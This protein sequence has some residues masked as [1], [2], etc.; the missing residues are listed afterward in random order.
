MDLNLLFEMN[1]EDYPEVGELLTEI[2]KWDR[3]ASASSYGAGAYAVFYYQLRPYYK[4]LGDDRIFTP[5]VLFEA[6]KTAKE[7]LKV[8]FNSKR[9]QLG[10][11][12]KLVRGTKEL[13]IFGL[14][15]VI[16]S[17]RGIP[18]KSGRI[19][20]AHGESYIAMIRFTPSRTYYESVIS[21]G[22]SRNP[23]SPHYTDQMELYAN[24]KTKTMSF[25]RA[26]VLKTAQRKY[27]PQ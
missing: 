1:P 4:Q 5:E 10:D 24:F 15:D 14:P 12:Q 7:Y 17:M 27:S 8:H 16:T 22:N 6:L 9:I 19:K 11:F 3:I 21:F 23:A 26:E 20:I 18:Y 13:P 2:Q 25:E